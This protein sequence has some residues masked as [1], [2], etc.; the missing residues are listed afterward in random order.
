MKKFVKIKQEF[1]VTAIMDIP[2]GESEEK[3][4]QRIEKHCEN[5]GGAE[6]VITLGGEI[7]FKTLR[8]KPT[9][10]DED[11]FECID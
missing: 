4:L 2:E 10:K 1:W 7:T 3:T 6:N 5:E 9:E 8:R 11:N